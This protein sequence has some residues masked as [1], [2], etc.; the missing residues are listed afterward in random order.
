M[1]NAECRVQNEVKPSAT[2]REILKTTSVSPKRCRRSII[3]CRNRHLS[4]LCWVSA[5]RSSLPSPTARRA[6]RWSMPSLP[7]PR[8]ADGSRYKQ[9][10]NAAKATLG[11]LGGIFILQRQCHRPR[12]SLRP[13]CVPILPW[14]HS[15][16]I[17]SVRRPRGQNRSHD[18]RRSAE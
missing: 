1:Q 10:Q 5:T 17:P 6:R 8:S 15:Y 12:H 18:T 4:T 16:T 7:P 14:S 9:R 3:C 13:T 2:A 11:C